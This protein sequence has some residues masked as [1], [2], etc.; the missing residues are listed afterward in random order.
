[1]RKLLKASAA[2]ALLACGATVA[3]AQTITPDSK[4]TAP[5]KNQT[6][7]GAAER[8][9]PAPPAATNNPPANQGSGGAAMG[10]AA[11]DTEGGKGMT[12]D[13]VDQKKSPN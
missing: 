12:K 7:P 10:P 3:L 11:G 13:K 8:P 5:P 4:Q 2:A 1:M 6:Q 9:A